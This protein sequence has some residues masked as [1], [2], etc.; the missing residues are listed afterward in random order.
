MKKYYH[1]SKGADDIYYILNCGSEFIKNLSTDLDIAKIKANKIVG[2]DVPVEIWHRKKWDKGYYKPQQDEHICDHNKYLEE[3]A[4]EKQKAD[5]EARQF[6][7]NIDDKIETELELT[8]RIAFENDWYGVSNICYFKDS[9]GNRFK[10]FGSCKSLRYFKKEGD[11][12][13]VSFKIKDHHFEDKYY[14]FDGVVPYKLN[15]IKQLKAKDDK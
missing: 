9:N 2:S 1:I 4:F 7:A 5:C 3:L 12:H 6:I 13:P 10:Y 11:K 15:L 8:K 14:K